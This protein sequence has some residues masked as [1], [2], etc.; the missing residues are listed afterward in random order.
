MN[1]VDAEEKISELRKK[2]SML[3]EKTIKSQI[4]NLMREN[5]QLKKDIDELK[6]KYNQA[7]LSN[8]KCVSLL[9]NGDSSKSDST[10]NNT[11]TA[12]KNRVASSEQVP[13][14]AKKEKQTKTTP[15]NSTPAKEEKSF[16]VSKLDLRIGY[17]REVSRHP[18][19]DTLYVEEIECGDEPGNESGFGDARIVC[20]GLVAA[21]EE[22]ELRNRMVLVMCNLKPAKM[23]GVT[24][25][26]MVMCAVEAGGKAELVDPPPG[27]K[28]GDR[29]VC[30]EYPGEP[31]QP[32]M[33]PKKNIWESVKGDLKV[34]SNG[35][36]RYKDAPLEVEGKGLLTAKLSRNCQ[37]S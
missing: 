30:K 17:I 12:T 3:R 28:V 20:S 27:A 33:H 23:R 37:V 35:V 18:D 22:S 2:V 1:I 24:S 8:G 13:K 6:S 29:V 26:A 4:A 19:A 34:D 14:K 5:G 16:D 36:V 7:L 11:E 10:G 25:Q 21:M 31:E 9:A 15:S 32:F